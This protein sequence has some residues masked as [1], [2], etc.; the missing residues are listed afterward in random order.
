MFG[1]NC[2]P[3]LH[4]DKHYPQM[5]RI[6]LPL[7]PHHLEGLLSAAKKICVQTV[8]SAQTVHQFD[9]EINTVSK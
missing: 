4:R 5:D 7:G 9:A 8:L 6:V 3:I 2:A 1:A